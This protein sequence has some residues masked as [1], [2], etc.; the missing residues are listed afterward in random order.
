MASLAAVLRKLEIIE[1]QLR[2]VAN[3]T[4][5]TKADVKSL[6]SDLSNIQ[7]TT[8]PAGLPTVFDPTNNSNI[9][10]SFRGVLPAPTKG[11][12]STE[13]S[14][15][16]LGR[17]RKAAIEV[18]NSAAKEAGIRPIPG[19]S[20]TPLY[21]SRAVMKSAESCIAI[22]KTFGPYSGKLT[23]TEIKNLYSK[24]QIMFNQAYEVILKRLVR[25]H[26]VLATAEGQWAANTAVRRR[27]IVMKE[28]I[29]AS[30]EKE[31][32]GEWKGKGHTE[33]STSDAVSDTDSVVLHE[34][35]ALHDGTDCDLCR[36]EDNMVLPRKI[37]NA[38]NAPRAADICAISNFV[39]RDDANESVCKEVRPVSDSSDSN[40][41]EDERDLQPPGRRKTRSRSV[42]SGTRKSA[43]NIIAQKSACVQKD[44]EGSMSWKDRM[45]DKSGMRYQAFGL[46]SRKRKINDVSE[47]RQK[48]HART[49]TKGQMAAR[50]RGRLFESDSE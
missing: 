23:F 22:C 8:G 49:E 15:F 18:Y 24:E 6:K 5:E 19:I 47:E 35:C 33:D 39:R 12:N 26:P 50:K 29:K 41:K 13:T 17:E 48:K 3:D 27:L 42:N 16:S 31:R 32:D 46:R 38:R 2:R 9:Y 37:F 20:Q 44:V 7:T 25:L 14:F 1:A 10:S 40:S 34:A 45:S 11:R 21:F 36:D 28:N 4:S 43:Q 30:L